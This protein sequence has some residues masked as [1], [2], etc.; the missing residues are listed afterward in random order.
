MEDLPAEIDSALLR[1]KIDELNRSGK[2]QDKECHKAEGERIIRIN[3]CLREYKRKAK[4]RL[5]SAQGLQHRSKR[6]KKKLGGNQ[7]RKIK[8]IY[9]L[10]IVFITLGHKKPQINENSRVGIAA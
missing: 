4:D 2:Y 6:P 7:T 5:T 3:H 10:E 1:A 9:T 8:A